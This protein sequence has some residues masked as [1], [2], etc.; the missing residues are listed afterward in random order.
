[1][2]RNGCLRIGIIIIDL[3][4]YK[5]RVRRAFAFL[6]ELG[7]HE[8][9]RERHEPYNTLC[10]ESEVC[11]VVTC[12]ESYG[13]QFSVVLIDK[14][15]GDTYPARVGVVRLKSFAAIERDPAY[16]G[17]LEDKIELFA[18]ALR[19]G[20]REFLAGNFSDHDE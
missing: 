16:G 18:E 10:F 1:M 8:V 5:R 11:R 17:E 14:H 12:T 20:G 6:K 7:F 15:P 13:S 2:L 19:I 3:V 4:G 9:P